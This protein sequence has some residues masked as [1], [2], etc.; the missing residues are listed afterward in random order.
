MEVQAN[1]R[2]AILS[3]EYSS[4][5]YRD[6]ATNLKK[7]GKNC[8]TFEKIDLD[9]ITKAYKSDI[10]QKNGL[11]PIGEIGIVGQARNAL[12]YHSTSLLKSYYAGDIDF[13]EVKK[14]IYDYVDQYTVECRGKSDHES[15]VK[16]SAVLS[17]L[18][19]YLSRANSRQAVDKNQNEA[20][21]FWNASGAKE[22][23]LD[24]YSATKGAVYYDSKYY[25]QCEDMQQMLRS[26][27]DE[28]A[29]QYDVK[30][31]EYE[32]IEKNTVFSLDGGI[33]FNGVWNHH[34]YQMNFYWMDY[35]KQIGI[36][37]NGF[38]PSDGF[39]YAYTNDVSEDS[40]KKLWNYIYGKESEKSD[41]M[42][43]DSKKKFLL[44]ELNYG[45]KSIKTDQKKIN[46]Y[47]KGLKVDFLTSTHT[48]SFGNYFRMVSYK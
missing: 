48:N 12:F 47:L 13:D 2:K 10:Y 35:E 38:V 1:Y 43:A 8:D 21:K 24:D 44:L 41:K 28:I 4:E 32:T 25:R 11:S 31:V 36:V 46:D 18:Y 19:E 27:F 26:T 40:A 14:Q 45:N 30:R 29:D 7:S 3:R 9:Q 39:V 42:N 17:D 34:Q 5:Q 37:D 16:I 6:S 20:I 22:T 33:T 15:K 23:G